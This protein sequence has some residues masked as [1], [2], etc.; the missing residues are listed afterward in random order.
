MNVN[1]GVQ[2]L[3]S[4]LIV[5]R[6]HSPT[7]TLRHTHTLV[8]DLIHRLAIVGVEEG[9][10]LTNLVGARRPAAGEI[11]VVAT[12]QQE[13]RRGEISPLIKVPVYFTVQGP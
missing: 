2:V 12:D 7:N 3:Q 5:A 1:E 9:S 13:V 8:S 10:I 6:D 4:I 11:S